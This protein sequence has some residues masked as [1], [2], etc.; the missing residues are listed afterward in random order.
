MILPKRIKTEGK[1][2]SMRRVHC[3]VLA[4]A[5]GLV[6][7]G[8]IASSAVAGAIVIDDFNSV[9]NP[10]PWPV[11]L[12]T[13]GNIFVQE[14]GLTAI[15]GTR[16]TYLEATSVG[17]PGLDNVQVSVVAAGGLFDYNSTA[18]TNGYVFM[19]YNAGGAGLNT[20]FSSQLGIWIHFTHF[21]HA[22]D[23]PLPITIHLFDGAEMAMQTISLTGPGAQ[24]VFFSFAAFGNIGALNLSSI[25]AI[26]IELDPA[27]G[28]DFRISQ[29][30]T[31]VPAPGALA[32][33]G[34]AAFGARRRR[35]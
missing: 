9:G 23:L 28:A 16:D 1:G 34:L 19:S 29:I 12:N 5:A 2:K 31:E 35:N 7:A 8:S 13:A 18:D 25:Q 10:N 15:G 4:V 33:F 24:S 14:T 6:A 26:D 20:D 22:G 21:D 30:I 32:L 11:T 17:V 3:G 27:T